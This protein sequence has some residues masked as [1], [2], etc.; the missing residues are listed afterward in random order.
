MTF[1]VGA[2]VDTGRKKEKVCRTPSPVRRARTEYNKHIM[3][4]SLDLASPAR[5]TDIHRVTPGRTWQ[6]HCAQINNAYSLALY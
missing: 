4:V 3:R 6:H 2:K 5:V 1:V